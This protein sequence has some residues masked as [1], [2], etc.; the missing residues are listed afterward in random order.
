MSLRLRRRSD[1][2][3]KWFRVIKYMRE[4]IR[5]EVP[6]PLIFREITEKGVCR[7]ESVEQIKSCLESAANPLARTDKDIINS[8]LTGLNNI[9]IYGQLN[10]CDIHLETLR[11]NMDEA[12]AEYNKKSKFY[13]SM[14]ILSGA[15]LVIVF[16]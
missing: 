5:L 1:E 16:I 15:F 10:N 3:E 4:R 14:G 11:S 7:L 8:F 12:A 9:D 2:L 6:I 13:L